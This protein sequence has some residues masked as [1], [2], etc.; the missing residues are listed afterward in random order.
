MSLCIGPMTMIGSA[1]TVLLG[2]QTPDNV[3]TYIGVT[4][5]PYDTE[6]IDLNDPLGSFGIEYDMHKHLRLFA[7]HLSSPMQ[8]DDHPGINHA[9][10]KFLAPL[11]QDLTVY[12]GISVNNSKFDSKDN[13]EGPLGSI[14]IEYGK[15]LKLFAEYLSSIK[16]F[17]GGR[18]SLGLKYFFH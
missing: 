1:V 12:S 13:F 10:V 2:T 14:G 17:E 15:D 8:C 16:E 7:E 6:Q 4:I 3:K 5:E 9:G 18:T 11:S